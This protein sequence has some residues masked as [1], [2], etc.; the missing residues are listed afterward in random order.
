MR[1]LVGY[2]VR[3]DA[4]HLDEQHLRGRLR[5]R[6]PSYMVPA[7]IDTLPALPALLSGKVDRAALPPPRGREPRARPE[8]VAPRTA[9][10][11]KIVTVWE[12]LFAPARVSIRDDFFTDLGGHS[13]LAAGMVS[14]LR[15]DPN[16]AALS[17]RDVYDHPTVQA[18]AAHIGGLGSAPHPADPRPVCRTSSVRHFLCGLAQLLSLYFVLGINALGW[19]AP[20]LAY[21]SLVENEYETEEALLGAFAAL[22][23]VYPAMLLVGLAV[24]WLV[25]GRFKAG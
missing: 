23:C 24:K 22:L 2:V 6:L 4:A 21:T 1:Q 10:E 25:I 12:R 19:L 5:S 13:L 7:V 11:E 20:Y 14:E 16:F 15:K 8:D 17:V 18:L 3:R 9:L